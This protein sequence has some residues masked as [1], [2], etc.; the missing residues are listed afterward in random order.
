MTRT[1]RLKRHEED[2]IH[3]SKKL[4]PLMFFLVLIGFR[5]YLDIKYMKRVTPNIG[6]TIIL[7]ITWAIYVYVLLAIPYYLEE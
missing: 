7:A 3:I 1:T 4:I 2:Y 5:V 6:D